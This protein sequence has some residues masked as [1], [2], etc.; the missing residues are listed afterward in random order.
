MMNANSKTTTSAGAD[1]SGFFEH[2]L[3]TYRGA[4]QRDTMDSSHPLWTR[5]KDAQVELE[6][7]GPVSKRSNVIVKWSTGQGVWAKVPW[8]ALLDTRETSFTND[9]V[10]VVYLFRMDMT[11]VYL[12][13]NQGVSR[14]R[15]R[16]GTSEA[17]AFIRNRAADLREGC[18][19][20][21]KHGFALDNKIDLRADHA[22]GADYE[23]ATIAYKLYEAGAVPDQAALTQDIE[24]VLGAYDDYLKERAGRC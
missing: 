3:E 13:L 24:A 23:M 11:G 7:L 21:K 8:I 1:L 5:F 20:L 15:D 17:R 22:L 14:K 10:Y 16:L 19:S 4:R 18:R 9:G 6:R 12:T 2:V